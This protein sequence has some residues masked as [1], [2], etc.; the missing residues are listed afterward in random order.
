M[1]ARLNEGLQDLGDLDER[2]Y[3]SAYLDELSELDRRALNERRVLNASILD[4]K[5]PMSIL[6]TPEEDI[7]VV[8][9]GTD[10]I[11]IQVLSPGLHLTE[12][13]RTA[14][15]VDDYINARFSYAFDEKYGYLTS[16]PTNVGTGMRATAI[17]HLPTLS[18]AKKF[19]RMLND[20]GRFG[21]CIR[22]VLWRGKRKLWSSL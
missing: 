12:A 22:G 2:D 4:K 17:V 20:M 11:R 3:E 18:M 9:N 10:H 8:L 19:L 5:E 1:L 21:V 15:K 16:F 13:L 14:D 7:S 6:I